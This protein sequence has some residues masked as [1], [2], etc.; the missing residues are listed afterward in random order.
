MVHDG[1][2]PD[3]FTAGCPTQQA[4]EAIADKWSVIVI[5]ALSSGTMRY[6]ELQRQVGGISQKMLTHTLRNLERNGL[7]D[8]KVYPVVPPKVEYSLTPLGQTIH[9]PLSAICLWAHHH[10]VEV[11]AARMRYDHHQSRS[12]EPPY[13]D[14]GPVNPAAIE[15]APEPTEAPENQA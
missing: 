4:I 10:F 13:D 9:E 6:N 1:F 14:R 15:R 11:E 7:V 2:K 5:Y 12:P 3:V 8:R